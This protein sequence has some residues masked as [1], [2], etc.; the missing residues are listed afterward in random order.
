MTWSN[1]NPF[2]AE[3]FEPNRRIDYVFAGWPKDDGAGHIVKC[4]VAG[5]DPVDG[6]HPSDHYA[7]VAELR[8]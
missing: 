1:A 7:V 3:A 5:K 6:I 4:T 2:A 8:Y